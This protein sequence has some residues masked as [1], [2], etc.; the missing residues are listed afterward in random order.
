M[1][2][3]YACEHLERANLRILG[4]KQILVSIRVLLC[5]LTVTAKGV[6]RDSPDLEHLLQ[7]LVLRPF[8]HDLTPIDNFPFLNRMVRNGR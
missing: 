8:D 3:L 1:Q 4:L 6:E 5:S 7:R 2:A